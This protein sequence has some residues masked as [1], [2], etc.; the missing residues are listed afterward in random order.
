MVI[1]P[2]TLTYFD[3]LYTL[4]HFYGYLEGLSLSSFF[5]PIY[6]D[7]TWKS[8]DLFLADVAFRTLASRLGSSTPATL[9]L[10]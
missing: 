7:S 9:R 2:F 1:Y 10:P 5:I 4:T 8:T 3:M 6:V